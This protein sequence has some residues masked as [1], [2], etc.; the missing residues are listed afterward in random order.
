MVETVSSR[1]AVSSIYP[2]GL[3][4]DVWL[5]PLVAVSSPR[6]VGPGMKCSWYFVTTFILSIYTV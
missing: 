5:L 6:S 4:A 1:A 3:W 2:S